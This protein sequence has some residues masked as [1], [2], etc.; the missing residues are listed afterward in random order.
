MSLPCGDPKSKVPI[1]RSWLKWVLAFEVI[2]IH[3]AVASQDRYLYLRVFSDGNQELAPLE[4]KLCNKKARYVRR[5]L[6]TNPKL[7]ESC[8]EDPR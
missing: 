1:N 3:A 2:A 8:S 6:R 4:N 5:D 7:S